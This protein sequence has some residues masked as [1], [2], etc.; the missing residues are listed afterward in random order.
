MRYTSVAGVHLL[1]VHLRALQICGFR[2][3]PTLLTNPPVAGIPCRI[4]LPRVTPVITYLRK[5]DNRPLDVAAVLLTPFA[6][7]A[8][9]PRPCS[10]P[11]RTPDAKLKV[12]LSPLCTIQEA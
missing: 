2:L 9:T 7:M 4:Y 1:G 12:L 6:G 11:R 3:Y 8:C 10:L 5:R